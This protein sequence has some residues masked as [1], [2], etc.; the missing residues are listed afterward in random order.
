MM[1]C[2]SAMSKNLTKPTSTAAT[3]H[4]HVI[5]KPTG[6]DFYFFVST[7]FEE[8]TEELNEVNY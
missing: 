8:L 1:L 4:I 7:I 2:D 3:D 5:S 6:Y